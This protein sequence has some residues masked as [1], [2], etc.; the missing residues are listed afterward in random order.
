MTSSLPPPRRAISEALAVPLTLFGYIFLYGLALRLLDTIAVTGSSTRPN[1]GDA[2]QLIIS[3]SVATV[4]FLI[5]FLTLVSLLE[6]LIGI[7][8][9][10]IDSLNLAIFLLPMIGLLFSLWPRSGTFNSKYRGCLVFADGVRTDCGS[11]VLVT[12]FLLGIS[13][14]IV[15]VFASRELKKRGRE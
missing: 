2:V 14:S 6:K 13:V 8:K 11:S 7:I 5:P 10:S 12:N 4:L 1:L 15:V 3:A 9:V